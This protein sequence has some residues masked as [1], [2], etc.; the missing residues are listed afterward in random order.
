M[1]LKAQALDRLAQADSRFARFDE[2]FNGFVQQ[3]AFFN[4]P[5][6]PLKGVE[7]EV[8]PAERRFT[9]KYRTLV[10]GFRLLFQLNTQG[11]PSAR[12][13]CTL[14]EPSSDK[15]KVS[16]GTFKFDP[17]GFTDFEVDQGAD[18]IELEEMAPEIL[19]HFIRLALE[20]GAA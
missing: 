17:Q 6:C 8:S 3:L 7:V 4:E 16:L 14:E 13:A 19:A 11:S 2:R 18:P 9:V 20:H 10:V 12:I 5:R 1:K 15:D